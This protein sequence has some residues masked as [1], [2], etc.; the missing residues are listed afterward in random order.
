MYTKGPYSPPSDNNTFIFVINDAFSHFVVTRSSR[1]N[2]S[3]N[4]IDTLLH[5]W[6]VKFGPLNI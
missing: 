3:Q 2:N 1:A 4:A 5:H 6:I